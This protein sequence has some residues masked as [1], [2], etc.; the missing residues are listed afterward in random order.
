M[1]GYSDGFSVLYYAVYFGIHK[2]VAPLL[3]TESQRDI[4]RCTPLTWAA[5]KGYAGVTEIL[6]QQANVSPN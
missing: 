6:L 5:E 2:L 1:S 4:W 3:N